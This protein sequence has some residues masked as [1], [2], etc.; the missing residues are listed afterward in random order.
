MMD[1]D[2]VLAMVADAAPLLGKILPI[3]GAGIAGALIAAEFGTQNTPQAIGAALAA[4]PNAYQKLKE[5]QETN[6]AA[7]QAQLIQLE[8]MSISQVNKTARQDSK[9]EDP[10]VRRARPFLI[11]AVGGSVVLEIIVGGAVIVIDPAAMVDFVSLCEAMAIPQS[12]A[13]TMCGI[14]MKQRSNDKALAA[15]HAPAAGLFQQLTAKIAG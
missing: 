13:G 5:L 8:T 12:V 9:S 15:G 10:F 7:L 1:W 6:K 3:P 2:S 11:W 4:D 14:Y